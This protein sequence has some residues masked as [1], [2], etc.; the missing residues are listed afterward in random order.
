MNSGVN[1]IYKSNFVES[2]LISVVVSILVIASR[3]L[4]FWRNGLREYSSAGDSFVWD[5]MAPYFSQS[6]LIAFVLNTG[7]VFIIAF[8]L[9]ELN[10]RFGIIRS[11]TAMPFYLPL[12]I[13]S[14]HPLFLQLTPALVA[15]IFILWAMFPLLVS[16]QQYRKSSVN[17][18]QFS[19][20][21]AV[22][23]LF[24]VPALALIVI[25]WFGLS[26]I[27]NFSLRAF[28]SSL[29]GVILV[30]WIMFAFYVCRA[31]VLDG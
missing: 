11:R 22:A 17:A 12:V 21:I 7:I 23:G 29:F 25:W 24:Y 6:P 18:F 3:F 27:G 31:Y 30:Y 20:L 4:M 5:Y 9:S 16:Y 1:R 10:V 15:V 8:L 13:F 28:F 14:V 26:A 2:R 19:V